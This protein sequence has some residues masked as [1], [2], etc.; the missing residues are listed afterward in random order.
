[1]VAEAGGASTLRWRGVSNGWKTGGAGFPRI[2]N[3]GL[4]G[5]QRGRP[6]ARNQRESPERV[7]RLS[8]RGGAGPAGTGPA[9]RGRSGGLRVVHELKVAVAGHVLRDAAGGGKA[10]AGVDGPAVGLAVLVAGSFPATRGGLREKKEIEKQ[11]GQA[12]RAAG[13]HALR[14]KP[15]G[16]GSR[17]V[18]A[19]GS[20]GSGRRSVSHGDTEGA[21]SVT[22]QTR[23]LGRRLQE[24]VGLSAGVSK[25]ATPADQMK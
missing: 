24:I 6:S 8:G 10:A 17:E 7:Q 22:P 15:A 12:G 23:P 16:K 11:R 19:D 13:S 18:R 3:A 20:E 2:G 21:E 9:G 14:G 25:L 5:V 4:R 1:M